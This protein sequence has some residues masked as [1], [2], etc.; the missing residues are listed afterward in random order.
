[1]SLSIDHALLSQRRQFIGM[2]AQRRQHLV[3]VPAQHW[4]RRAAAPATAKP[5][6]QQI[7]QALKNAGSVNYLRLRIK[8]ESKLVTDRNLSAGT[9][10]L[11]L[12]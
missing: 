12:T 3:G 10:G 2:Q 8:L 6:K 5:S 7:Q 9:E 1:M 11:K 4:R